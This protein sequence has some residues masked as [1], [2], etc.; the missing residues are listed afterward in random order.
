MAMRSHEITG[1]RQP[2]HYHP[3]PL[4]KIAP[5]MQ[6]AVLIGEDQRF[7][8]HSGID[9]I[10]LRH[11]LGYQPD[12]FSWY[13]AKDR[14]LLW[15]SIGRAWARRARLRG[16][17]TLSQ[18]LAKNL[19]L[20]DSRS[21]FRKLKEAVTAWR[22]EYW[23]GKERIL[24]L[25]LNVVEL[26][27]G[28]WGV[29]AASQKYFSHSAAT[30]SL[31]EAAALGGTLPFPLTSNPSYRPSR[32]RGRQNK[33]ARR[34]RGEDVVVPPAI[35][36]LE[37]QPDTLKAGGDTLPDSTRMVP[38]SV[39]DTLLNGNRTLDLPPSSSNRPV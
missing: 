35:D 38:D 31:E 28:V 7:Y 32:M 16:A 1:V 4:E 37:R 11:A 15:R 19:Y 21:P 18:Q 33:I 34:L 25:Y 39:A 20:S 17:S 9:F 6:S 24:E 3:V 36:S 2:L 22:L 26:G 14:D 30:L 13:S 8:Q 5:I 12:S 27:P 29:E 10:E 23:L